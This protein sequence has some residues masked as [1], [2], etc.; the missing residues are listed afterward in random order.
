MI[1]VRNIYGTVIIKDPKKKDV[2]EIVDPSQQAREK[3]QS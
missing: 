1:R 3:V 2:R